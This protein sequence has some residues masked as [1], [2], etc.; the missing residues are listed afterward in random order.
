MP[1][2]LETAIA[3]RDAALV[4]RDAAVVER[5]N[6]SGA[7]LVFIGLGCPRQ[8]QFAMAHRDSIHAVQL[9]VGAA[10]DFHAGTKGIAPPWMQKRGTEWLF[11]LVQE[12][13]R[14]LKRYL[15]T[16]TLFCLLVMRRLL[17]GR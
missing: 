8:E 4:E 16:N 17:L 14:L 13:R 7:G 15:A 3:E 12:P 5:I 9:C 6:R 1:T 10:F 11:R 2:P